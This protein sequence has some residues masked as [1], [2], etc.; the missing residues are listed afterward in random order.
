MGNQQ[1]TASPK[2]LSFDKSIVALNLDD[3]ALIRLLTLE[4]LK[5]MA[6]VDTLP[7]NEAFSFRKIDELAREAQS[8]LKA[9]EDTFFSS[10]DHI[11]EQLDAIFIKWQKEREKIKQAI[12]AKIKKSLLYSGMKIAATLI[13]D[14]TLELKDSLYQL[15]FLPKIEDSPELASYANVLKKLKQFQVG[16][17]F[18]DALG[19]TAQTIVEIDNFLEKQNKELNGLLTKLNVLNMESQHIKDAHPTGEEIKSLAVSNDGKM[20]ASGSNKGDI[21]IW[22]SYTKLLYHH[23]GGAH[24]SKQNDFERK[25]FNY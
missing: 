1:E 11:M 20:I 22:R 21:K 10:I 17:P 15:G 19:K 16:H 5:D 6:G 12:Q 7:I 23:F 2:Q 4:N 18:A 14:L 3:N 9:Q 25:R 24:K 13:Q 8:K